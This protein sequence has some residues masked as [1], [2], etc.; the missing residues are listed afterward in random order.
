[1]LRARKILGVVLAVFV[2]QA[3]AADTRQWKTLPAAG[4]HD[5]GNPA[6]PSLQNPG[7]ALRL[8]P[9]DTAG[10]LVNWVK[11]LRDGYIKPRTNL[12]ETTK[13]RVLD[14]DIVMKNT[15][16]MPYVRFPHLAHTE[17]LECANC[18]EGLFKSKAGATPIN[19]FD[20]LQGEYCGRCHGA[21]AFPLTEC[22]RCHNTSRAAASSQGPK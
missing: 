6:L 2:F 22:A 11:A 7:A 12:L 3:L 9:P 13:V 1:M 15:A 20:I 14:T 10:N 17:W 16:E 19:M 5:P 18:H 21:V 4:L 8:L